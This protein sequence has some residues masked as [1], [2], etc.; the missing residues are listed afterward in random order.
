MKKNLQKLLAT[1]AAILCMMAMM[2]L[3]ARAQG[4]VINT[5]VSSEQ[6][7]KTSTVYVGE[8]VVDGVS[9]IKYLYSGDVSTVVF[10]YQNLLDC[11]NGMADDDFAALLQAN[12]TDPDSPPQVFAFCSDS[13][14]AAAMDGNWSSA[15]YVGTL[16]YPDKTVA[17]AINSNLYDIDNG[18]KAVVDAKIAERAET[19]DNP[20]DAEKCIVSHLNTD[21]NSNVYY[22]V[23]NGQVIKHV[24]TYVV[25]SSEATT[26]IYTKVE[27]ETPMTE[28]PLTFEAVEEGTITV[29]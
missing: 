6:L 13:G 22:T 9:E 11:L 15:Q 21:I 26:V 17:S 24:D 27:L 5:V 1:F 19:V 3:K 20:I 7:S 2:P 28:T 14:L 16:Y 23:E 4:N 29:N 12:W 25:Y 8:V 18:F 10:V